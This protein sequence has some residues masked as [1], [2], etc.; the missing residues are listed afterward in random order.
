[1]TRWAPDTWAG[2]TVQITGG[3]G[4]GQT[5]TITGNTAT[6]LTLS[7]AWDT[8]PDASS[9]YKI[10]TV[11]TLSDTTK[12]W[13]PNQWVGW[14]VGITGGKGV[15]QQGTVL[16]NTATQLTLSGTW[17][18]V[19]DS[20]SQYEIGFSVPTGM[21]AYNGNLL[22]TDEPGGFAGADPGGV[23]QVNITTGVQTDVSHGGYLVHATDIAIEPSGSIIPM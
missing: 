18:T 4:A 11:T 3:T 22:V 5:R 13:T 10:G 14:T 21:R 15:T 20:T 1:I 19:P 2:Y 8:I 23:L 9:T 7:S 17:K 6:Q 12:N 16:S